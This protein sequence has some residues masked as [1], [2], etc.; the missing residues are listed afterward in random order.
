M[1]K[2]SSPPAA[3]AAD[4]RDALRGG[5]AA[6]VPRRSRKIGRRR[7]AQVRRRRRH[8]DRVR[9]QPANT[10]SRSS[11]SRCAMRSRACEPEEYCESRIARAHSRPRRSSGDAGMPAET[12]AFLDSRMA[13]DTTAP[14]ADMQ[15]WVLASYPEDD[16]GHPALGL[17]RRSR[18]PDAQS[19][20]RRRD[21]RQGQDRP[22]RLPPPTS[23]PDP[24]D[25]PA[26][27]QRVVVERN[28]GYS[29]RTLTA[30]W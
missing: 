22:V 30:T 16:A 17:D 15:R 26:G 6:G 13:F 18:T 10:S 12:A 23:R 27:L 24:R 21:L 25:V 29:V 4:G 5:D 9:R 19:R 1:T 28:A 8:A 2:R 3:A 14:A 7:A 11:T 20:R